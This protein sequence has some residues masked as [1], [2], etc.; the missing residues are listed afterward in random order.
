MWTG[1]SH[2]MG[3]LLGPRGASGSGKGPMMNASS[4]APAGAAPT[5]G[6]TPPPNMGPFPAQ[7][8]PYADPMLGMGGASGQLSNP[9]DRFGSGGFPGGGLVSVG[10]T[11]MP[12]AWFRAKKALPPQAAPQ[13]QA[14]AGGQKGLT[15]QQQ[16][17]SGRR[18]DTGGGGRGGWGGPEGSRDRASRD[19]D[20]GR[21]GAGRGGA[22]AGGHDPSSSGG[23]F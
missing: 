2:P 13:A 17:R 20:I 7:R 16:N 6:M 23:R 18:G 15:Q 14:N 19:R 12:E 8:G 5:P 21:S 22:G 9:V 3:Q 10:G 1:S 4:A 11:M